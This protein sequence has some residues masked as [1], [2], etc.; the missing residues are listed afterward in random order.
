[1]N[2]LL[3]LALFSILCVAPQTHSQEVQNYE[4]LALPCMGAIGRYVYQDHDTLDEVKANCVS[5]QSDDALQAMTDYREALA[6]F[7]KPFLDICHIQWKEDWSPERFWLSG[8]QGETFFSKRREDLPQDLDAVSL[9]VFSRF[10]YDEVALYKLKFSGVEGQEWNK[11]SCYSYQMN[12]RFLENDFIA[13]IQHT[14]VEKRALDGRLQDDYSLLVLQVLRLADG[15]L[16]LKKKWLE[17]VSQL[18]AKN[19]DADYSRFI[20]LMKA[21]IEKDTAD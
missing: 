10:E 15:H 19:E 1:M 13:Y 17:I 3:P 16:P 12:K 7:S 8:E 4:G 6:T 9:E 11:K 2:K 5:A 20:N 21:A 18:D 14:D